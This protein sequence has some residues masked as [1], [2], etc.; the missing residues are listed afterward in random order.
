MI[1]IKKAIFSTE[2]E[3][4]AGEKIEALRSEVGIVDGNLACDETATIP[5]FI[6]KVAPNTNLLEIESGDI[7]LDVFEVPFDGDN[8]Y[9]NLVLASWGALDGT[10]ACSVGSSGIIGIFSICE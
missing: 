4:E 6:Q 8:L 1:N 10:R 2:I 7:L 5:C 9:Y 3:T